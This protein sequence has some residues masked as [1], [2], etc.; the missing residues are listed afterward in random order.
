MRLGKPRVNCSAKATH[1]ITAAP[2]RRHDSASRTRQDPPCA[3]TR[4]VP[5]TSGGILEEWGAPRAALRAVTR[6]VSGF[7]PRQHDTDYGVDASAARRARAR[8]DSTASALLPSSRAAP[9]TE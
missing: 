9:G 3:Q 2:R 1:R 4:V 5:I 7:Q 8:S 6:E